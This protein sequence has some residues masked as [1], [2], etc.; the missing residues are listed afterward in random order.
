MLDQKLIM[1]RKNQFYIFLL[2]AL[3]LFCFIS[4]PQYLFS[5]VAGAK[6][7]ADA[8]IYSGEVVV[9][10][11]NGLK[12]TIDKESGS[13]VG[14]EYPG[15][16]EILQAK[17]GMGGIIDV[18]YPIPEFEPLR[19]ASRFSKGAKIEISKDAVLITWDNLGASREY[20][21]SSGKVS[22][23]VW[24]QAMPDGRS[25]SMKCQVV[26]ESERPVGQVLFPDFHGLLPIAGKE[27]T[28]FRTPGFVRKPF[29]DVGAT[30]YPEFYAVDRRSDTKDNLLFTG[31]FKY[32]EGDFMIGR[33]FDYGGLNGGISLFPKVWIDA[34]VTKIRIFR[35]EKDPNV[36]L[37]HIHDSSIKKGETWNSPE[38]VLTPHRNGWAKGIEPYREFVKSKIKRLYPIPKHIRE[39]FGYRTIWVCK[40]F[41]ADGERDVAFKFTDLPKVARESKE[42]GLDELVIWWWTECFQVP[43]LGPYSH[44]GTPEELSN[45]I[46]ECNDIG[47]NISL[48][49]SLYS[50]SDPTASRYGL[51]V[52][53]SDYTYH[54][55]LI[56]RISTSYATSRRVAKANTNDPRWRMDVMSSVKN[57]YEK[58][59]RSICWDENNLGTES[60]IKEFLPLAKKGDPRATFSG[61][62][63]GSAEKS[64]EFLDYTW[65]WESGS[66]HHNLLTP[67][68]DDRAFISSFPSPRLN[69]N[70]N[71][72]SEHIKYY[73]MDNGYVNV[74]P[75]APD[76]ANGTGW[77]KDYPDVSAILKQCANLKKQFL[78]YFTDGTLI[79]ECLLKEPSTGAHMNAYVLPDRVLFLIMNTKPNVRKINFKVDLEPWMKSSSGTYEINS[80]DQF[81][82]KTKTRTIHSFNWTGE[83]SMLKNNDMEIFEFIAK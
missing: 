21:K 71:R 53:P 10:N 69:K 38:Y 63:T 17:T 25:I 64:A 65:N 42:H 75:S 33:W 26:N 5:Q 79:G 19:L 58:Y 48:F 56:P 76:D 18:A 13:I 43:I 74:M 31:G 70:I 4:L 46:K 49:I 62:I 36:R 82:K 73:F 15:P 45:A 40:G 30:R 39:G 78:E 51:K 29:V 34:P 22:A 81:G 72:N 61:E 16:G 7:T 59:T 66:F 23:K 37:I 11:L 67:Y 41:P 80:Y 77:I 44:L 57:I 27:E 6:K 14:L 35:M 28:Y 55:E 8:K 1:R 68:R 54:P 32:G 9:A 47:V 83:T 12:I 50:L 52:T 60:I 2:V 20:F 24:L 3:A